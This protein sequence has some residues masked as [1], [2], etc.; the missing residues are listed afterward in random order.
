MGDVPTPDR[1]ANWRRRAWRNAVE[2]VIELERYD[3]GAKTNVVFK[4]LMW[5]GSVSS[6]LKE[7]KALF[8]LWTDNPILKQLEKWSDQ[9]QKKTM[10]RMI[11]E[12]LGTF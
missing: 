6:D 7:G 8:D 5:L 11:S 3:H 9:S 12:S 1:E 10:L 2:N 4:G